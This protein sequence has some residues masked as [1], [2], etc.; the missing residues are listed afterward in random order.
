MNNTF[1]LEQIAKTGDLN[2][3]L[4]TRH[5]KLDK[6]AKL[7]EI[8]SINPKIKESQLAQ[9]VTFYITAVKRNK[10]AITLN[11][12]ENPQKETKLIQP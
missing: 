11:N 2:V 7:F 5:Y 4:I 8:K 10:Y 3:E 9:N 1:S 6:K 12:T